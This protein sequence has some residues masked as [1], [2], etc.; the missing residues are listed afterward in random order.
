MSAKTKSLFGYIFPAMGGLFVTYLYNVVD[1]IFVGQGVGAA[2]LGAVNIG[3]PFITFVVAIAAMFPMGGATVVAIR[4]GRGDKD[5]GNDY[6]DGVFAA[7]CRYKRRK[8]IK[9]GNAGNVCRLFVLLFC[10]FCSHAY[11]YLSFCFC[12][13]RWFCFPTLQRKGENSVFDHSRWIFR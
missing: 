12:E 9:Q 4:M 8:G 3:V 7:D 1:G 11:E 10:I 5:E 6:R 13:K 2:A